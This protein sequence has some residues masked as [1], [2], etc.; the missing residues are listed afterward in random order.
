MQQQQE[1]EGIGRRL[2]GPSKIAHDQ[3]KDGPATGDDDD[4]VN[5]NERVWHHRIHK[6]KAL[7]RRR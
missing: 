2:F 1:V 3:P 5:V 4:D 7:V 6:T